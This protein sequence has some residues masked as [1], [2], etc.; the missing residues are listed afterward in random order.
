MK[1][2][3]YLAALTAILATSFSS[4]EMKEDDIFA[5]DPATRQDEWMAEYRRVF[6]NN[7]HGWALYISNP[8]Y[9]R[10]PQVAT[11]AVKFDQEYCTFYPSSSTSRIPSASGLAS[12]T[13]TYA[14]KMDNGVVLSFDTYNP[15]FHYFADQSQYFSQDLQSSFEFCLD[16]FSANEDTIFGHSKT[17]SLPMFMVKMKTTPQEYQQQSDIMDQYAA[18]NC[19]MV[20]A[21]DTLQARFLSGYHNFLLY[22]PDEEGG[23]NVEHMYSYGNLVGGLYFL[24]NI[25]Y[26][27]KTI[28]EMKLDPET[29]TFYDPLT[30]AKIIGTPLADYFFNAD[31]EDNLYWGYSALG[32]WTKQQWDLAREDIGKAR[33]F[34]AN[35]LVYIN[36]MPD[37]NGS[38]HL[39]VN[40]WYG[41]DEVHYH[42]LVK[43]LADNRI[44]LQYTGHETSGRSWSFYD[45]GLKRIVD[46]IAP[47]GTWTNYT[48]SF[49]SGNAMQPSELIL[50]DESNPDN[51][52]YF[53]TNFH[54]YHYS[55]WE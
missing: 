37:G 54:Y 4:C 9:G 41:A 30:Q 22:F 1:K 44:A 47:Q 34:S 5:K 39:I 15:F 40:K 3:L 10:H 38:L 6:N 52:F 53:P 55:I 51:S 45:N 33:K 28:V 20:I 18:Y 32:S 14:F 27:G 7:E 49:R 35:S 43:K 8:T 23:P 13:S 16:R 24:E 31:Y 12:A 50:T 48:V 25:S 21:G 2:H 36:F 29:G 19:S 17:N 26:K 11:Y 46:A 42:F